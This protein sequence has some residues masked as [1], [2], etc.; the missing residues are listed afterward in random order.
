M[1]FLPLRLGH[2]AWDIG[3]IHLGALYDF[4]P[5]EG[6]SIDLR[7]VELGPSDDGMARAFGEMRGGKG[8]AKTHHMDRERDPLNYKMARR[9]AHG[10]EKGEA[11]DG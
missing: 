3:L 10:H 9:G 8:Q 6:G 5:R 4:R 2:G 1:P 7:S 11:G